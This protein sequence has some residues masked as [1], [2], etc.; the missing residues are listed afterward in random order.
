MKKCNKCNKTKEFDE[1]GKNKQ[2]ADGYLNS[3][4][5]CC[6]EKQYAKRRTKKGL[7]ADIYDSQKQRSKT[8][9][10]TPPTY[11]LFGLRQWFKSSAV[12]NALYD[13]WVLS[14][15][16]KNLRPSIDRLNDDKGYSFDN[17]QLMTWGENMAKA[18]TDVKS[19]KI[20]ARNKAVI[21]LDL[22]G[23]LIAEHHSASEASRTTN[24]GQTLISGCCNNSTR[25]KT[26]GG[27][28][29]KHS[30]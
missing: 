15:Y 21:Q 8:R 18:N 2:M 25:N 23:N 26:A 17:I 19:G 30:A 20:K 14:G 13:T 6:N 9:G 24:I 16:A 10:H 4:K 22:D 12:A 3:C 7:V 27:F 29:W 5:I 1:F 11:T 28:K